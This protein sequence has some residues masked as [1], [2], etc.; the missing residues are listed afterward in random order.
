M[1]STLLSIALAVPL[2]LFL[3]RLL[4][5]RQQSGYP[6]W[7]SIDAD[8]LKRGGSAKKLEAAAEADVIVIGSGLG[9]LSS[10]AVLSKAG[11]KVVVLEQHDV[12][13]GLTWLGLGL[14]LG[15]GLPPPPPTPTPTIN[16]P[17]PTFSTPT[18]S[19]SP[20]TPPP[21]PPPPPPTPPPPPPTTGATHTFEDGGYEFDVG[22][23]YL[24]GEMDR[25][26]SPVRRLFAAISDGQ[27][28]WSKCDRDYDVCY[29]AQTVE[30]IAF[31][32]DAA[33]D[34]ARIAA[35][36]SLAGTPGV[37][38]ALR[39]Y[40]WQETLA[41]LAGVLMV[42]HKARPLQSCNP[43]WWALQPCVTGAATLCGRRCSPVW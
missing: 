1:L 2:V 20:L 24:G 5:K 9:G 37:R 6:S 29:N 28:E 18:T 36:A 42:V 23:H 17:T 15:L 10:A 16:T 12:I 38:A 4:L 7:R 33:T 21:P 30:S 34:E 41:Q 32:G 35:A 31:C 19:P 43:V 40:R 27:L 25:F 13:G 11:Y 26:L 3:C 22:I 8:E 14:E 39:A